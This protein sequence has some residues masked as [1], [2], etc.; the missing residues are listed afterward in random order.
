MA[1]I[2]VHDD[3]IGVHHR[4]ESP[5]TFNRNGRSRWAGI[6]NGRFWVSTEDLRRSDANDYREFLVISHLLSPRSKPHQIA[7]LV[8]FRV[9]RDHRATD[10][11]IERSIDGNPQRNRLKGWLRGPQPPLFAVVERGCL[12]LE[13]RPAEYTRFTRMGGGP[14]RALRCEK[15][16]EKLKRSSG[17]P[18]GKHPDPAESCTH[19]SKTAHAGR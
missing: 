15:W 4:A 1:G 17:L 7:R 19:L 6:R 11:R 16:D 5:F 9:Y 10:G 2:G 13:D 12:R 14:F 18:S 3:R 8:R